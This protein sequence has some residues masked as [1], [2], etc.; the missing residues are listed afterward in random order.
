MVETNAK[1]SMLDKEW[2]TDEVDTLIHHYFLDQFLWD[3]LPILT[4]QRNLSA[5]R[6]WLKSKKK[7]MLRVLIEEAILMKML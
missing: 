7:H 6:H 2:T 1:T 5:K 4:I 3:I